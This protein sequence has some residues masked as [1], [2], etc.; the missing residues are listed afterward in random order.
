MSTVTPLGAARRALALFVR[1]VARRAGL[2]FAGAL[3]VAVAAAAEPMVLRRLV[4]FLAAVGPGSAAAA[5]AL[6]SAQVTRGLEAWVGA[7]ALV[8]ALRTL[9]HARVTVGVWKVRLGIEYQLRSRVAAKFSVLSGRTQAEIGTGGLRYAIESSAPQA[10]AAFSDVA[11]RLVPTLVYVAGAAWGMIQLEGTIAAAV[12]C[13]VPIP[14]GVAALATRHQTARARAQHSFW[15]GLWAWYDEV[16]HGMG[17]V[18]A[19]ANERA[20]ERRFMRRTRWVF[21]SIS[22]GVHLDAQVTAAAGLSELAARVVV[23]GYGGLLV[24]RGEL[25][26]GALLALWGYVG[27]VFAPVGLLVEVW[28]TLRRAGVALDA[29]FRVLDAEEEAPDLPG[30]APAPALSGRVTFEGVRFGYDERA[31]ARGGRPALDGLTVDIAPGQTVALVGPSGSGKSTVLR[32]VQRVHQPT[33]GRVLLDGH[34]LRG[35]EAASVRRQLGVVPQE[36]VLFAGSVAANIAYG[37]PSAT[38][39][40]VEAAARAANA[41]DFIAALPGG[42]EHRVAEGGRGLSGGQRQRIAIARAFLVDP[43]VLLLDEATAALDTESERQVQEALKALRAGRTTL[44]VAHRLNTIR[45]ADRILVLR[46]GRVVGDGPHDDLVRTCPTYQA[47]VREQM[48]A[49]AVPAL[50]LAA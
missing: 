32:L 15:T 33:A 49:G 47:L 45:D 34:D 48:G 19:F 24:A 7:V 16:L 21:A 44:V 2:T 28:P 5:G 18:R 43:A 38:R 50:G 22:K 26:I 41:H 10:A 42:Y 40:E 25:T 8:I 14:A 9:G 27:G 36:V 23:L 20:E 6:P 35:L 46:D 13:L 39:E 3:A 31:A 37:R 29:V 4:D 11:Y 1:P 12:L 30:A 17:T